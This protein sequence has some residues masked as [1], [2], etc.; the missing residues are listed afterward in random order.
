LGL[1]LED[2]EGWRWTA[3]IHPDDVAGIVDKWRTCLTS[4]EI[5]EYEPACDW[6]HRKVSC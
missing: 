3:T 1:S 2:V 5:F 4:G 6:L